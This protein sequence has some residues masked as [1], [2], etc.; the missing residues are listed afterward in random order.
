MFCTPLSV[1]PPVRLSVHPRLYVFAISPVSID[2][3]SPS[4]DGDGYAMQYLG[5][6]VNLLGLGVK[7]SKVKAT[8]SRRRRPVLDA[9]HIARFL[10]Q[11]RVCL[12]VYLSV[13]RRLCA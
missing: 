6:K 9:M 2:G 7:K 3:F 11:R 4:M 12:S 5:T 13:T 10:R 1:L 8:L